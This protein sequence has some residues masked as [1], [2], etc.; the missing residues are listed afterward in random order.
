[1]AHDPEVYPDPLNFVPERWLVENP[2]PHPREV[3]FGFGRRYVQHDRWTFT[4]SDSSRRICPGILLADASMFI[5][6]TMFLALFDIKRVEGSPESFNQMP[7][8]VLDGQA[9][10]YV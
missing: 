8:G 6:T 9:I 10:W 2:P 4:P 3:S 5:A 7:G 1:M